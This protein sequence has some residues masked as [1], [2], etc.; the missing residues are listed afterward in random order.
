M[1]NVSLTQNPVPK[2]RRK[3][4]MGFGEKIIPNRMIVRVCVTACNRRLNA[5]DI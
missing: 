5:A 2:A 1:I 3:E 4:S